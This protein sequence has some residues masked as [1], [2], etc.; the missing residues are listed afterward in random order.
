M[1]VPLAGGAAVTLATGVGGS[2]WG[3]AVNDTAIYFAGS[4]TIL[5]LAK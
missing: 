1:R 4:S 5:M 3:L 2:G